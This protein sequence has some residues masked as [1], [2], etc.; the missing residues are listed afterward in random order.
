MPVV[1]FSLQ[2]G[3]KHRSTIIYGLTCLWDSRATYSMI[4]ICHTKPYKRKMHSNK[5]EYSTVA[6]PHFPTHYVKVP[7]CVP[8]FSSSNI[9]SHRFHVD[10]NED[11]SG[12]FYDMIIGPNLIVQPG[13]SADLRFKS[14]NGMVL[15]YQRKNPDL[16]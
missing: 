13:L 1:T 15:Q 12:I 6:G 8:E 3:K 2:G 4:K 9:I 10:N 7:F 5:V 11:E 16:C 14:L